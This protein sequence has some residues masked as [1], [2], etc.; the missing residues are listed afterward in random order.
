MSRRLGEVLPQALA[1][2]GGEARLK[3]A[4]VLRAW[5]EVAGPELAALTEPLALEDGVL[6]VGVENAALAHRLTYS[7]LALIRRYQ[8]L[9]PG[10]VREIRFRVEPLPPRPKEEPSPPGQGEAQPEGGEAEVEAKA[11]LLAQKAPPYL[12]AA[13]VR[14]AQALLAQPKTPPCPVCGGPGGPGPCPPCQR[15]LHTPLV[16]EE[17]ER[18]ARGRP[19]RLEGDL[20]RAAR[21]LARGI[22][23]AHLAELTPMAPKDPYLRPLVQAYAEWLQA[24]QEQPDEPP[25]SSAGREE[26]PGSR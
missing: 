2:L 6:W 4:Q 24:L 20:L 3:R 1:Q 11:R 23:Q 19:P 10:M 13:V 16:Q 5:R 21:Y 9:F 25:G 15:Q 18:L 22:L 12:Q 8:S 7:R 17:A 26:P 14:L